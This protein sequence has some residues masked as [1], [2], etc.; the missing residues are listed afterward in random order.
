MSDLLDETLPDWADALLRAP[1]ASRP[2]ARAAIMDAVRREPRP[3]MRPRMP[4]RAL[5]PSMR[6]PRWPRRGLLTPVGA[7]VAMLFAA[8]VSLQS[9]R[10]WQATGS[11]HTALHTAAYI[12]GDT[13]V[14]VA[15]DAAR[16][17]VGQVLHDTLRIVEFVLRGPGVRSAAVVGDFNA[18]RHGVTRLARGADGTWRARVVVP[19]DVVRFAYVVNDAELGTPPPHAGTG[20]SPA[21]ARVRLDSI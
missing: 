8:T 16:G 1:T 13:V 2:A 6:V 15:P 10:S 12:L 18:W 17:T 4:M 9:V 20:A 14:P 3:R 5:V 11:G 19:R 21:R 7:L